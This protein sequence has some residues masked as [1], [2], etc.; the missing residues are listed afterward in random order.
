M[1]IDAPTR[2]RSERIASMPIKKRTVYTPDV[3]IRG[4]RK[5][6]KGYSK[7]T[8]LN[9]KGETTIKKRQTK[10]QSTKVTKKKTQTIVVTIM[11]KTYEE[12]KISDL[13]PLVKKYAVTSE[14]RSFYYSVLQSTLRNLKEFGIKNSLHELKQ[15]QI[16]VSAFVSQQFGTSF[17]AIECVFDTVMNYTEVKEAETQQNQTSHNVD[18]LLTSLINSFNAVKI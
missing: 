6:G 14:Q 18:D 16:L 1:D 17:E 3:V 7:K 11:P 15:Q 12:W 13:F 8:T 10:K 4:R 2:R 9:V 5:H